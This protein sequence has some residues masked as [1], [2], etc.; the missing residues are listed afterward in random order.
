[1]MRINIQLFAKPVAQAE[2]EETAIQN[3]WVSRNTMVKESSQG[4]SYSDREA[5]NS[6]PV[7]TLEWVETSHSSHSKT[8]L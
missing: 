5:Q 6:G 1:M 7:R 4:T 3:T 8:V 2:T